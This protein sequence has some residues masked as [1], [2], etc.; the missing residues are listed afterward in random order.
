MIA[1]A[2]LNFSY[3]VD[4]NRDTFSNRGIN[5]Q[6]GRPPKKQIKYSGIS[7]NNMIAKAMLNYRLKVDRDAEREANA[8]NAVGVSGIDL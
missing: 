4:P 8:R 1:N 6:V 3:S 7:T 5:N 2:M